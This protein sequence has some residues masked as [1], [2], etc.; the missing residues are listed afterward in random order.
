MFFL[1]IRNE[2]NEN[3]EVLEFGTLESLEQKES[4]L[5]NAGHMGELVTGHGDN[6]ESFLA[7]YT[8]YRSNAIS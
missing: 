7:T 2:R 6:M 8:E 3:V 1:V 4:D 5:L